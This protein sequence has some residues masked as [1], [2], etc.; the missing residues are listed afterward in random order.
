MFT[1]GVDQ[2]QEARGD[3][4]VANDLHGRSGSQLS[5]ARRE[6]KR[7]DSKP[8]NSGDVPCEPQS[9][10][11][12]VRAAE[13]LGKIASA[14]EAGEDIPLTENGVSKPKSD[15]K[16]GSELQHCLVAA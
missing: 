9:L 8:G 12:E 13:D 14:E 4:G 11:C 7:P 3:S 2:R 15:D 16:K 10:L 5:L 6:H 1:A